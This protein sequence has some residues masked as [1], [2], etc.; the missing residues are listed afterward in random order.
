M[1][2]PEPKKRQPNVVYSLPFAFVAAG[3]T[4][5]GNI[6]DFCVEFCFWYHVLGGHRPRVVPCTCPS[7]FLSL[8]HSH[9]LVIAL[10]YA[11]ARNPS[12]SRQARG[13]NNRGGYPPLRREDDCYLLTIQST[14]HPMKRGRNPTH[15]ARSHATM[16]VT[17]TMTGTGI[18]I[19]Q[20]TTVL[21]GPPQGLQFWDRRTPSVP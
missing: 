4:W 3:S 5:L 19:M 21:T 1:C 15:I 2:A 16:H 13:I 11:P 20:A 8:H 6:R 9:S 17:A 10:I 14:N 18:T 7:L 12:P